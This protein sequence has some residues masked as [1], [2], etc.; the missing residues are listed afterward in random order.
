MNSKG[1]AQTFVLIAAI[2]VCL[3]FVPWDALERETKAEVK[4]AL[5][6]RFEQYAELRL[7]DDWNALYDM[8]LP[9]HRERVDRRTF[10]NF[11]GLGY[12]IAKEVELLQL[13]FDEQLNTG[14]TKLRVV[15]ELQADKLPIKGPL[16]AGK[17]DLI[18]ETELQLDWQRIGGEWYF[19]M[20]QDIVSGLSGGQKIQPMLPDDH[21]DKQQAK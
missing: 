15:V 11:H 7:A 17:D 10:L 16:K 21:P 19:A 3:Y 4:D 1:S 5:R 14:A 8:T 9:R 12:L 18:K 13:G 20:E 2:A 6:K